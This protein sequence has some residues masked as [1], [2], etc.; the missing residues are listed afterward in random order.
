[1][2]P[3]QRITAFSETQDGG[4]PAGVWIGDALP[5]PIEM[6]KIA[7]EVGYSET[8]FAAKQPDGT[9]KVRYYSPEAEVPFCGH[10]TI[11]LGA[12]LGKDVGDG[13]YQLETA[14]GTVPVSTKTIANGTRAE[15]FSV[16]TNSV[17]APSGLLGKALNTLSW[18]ETVLH[19]SYPPAVAF[20]GAYH[21]ILALKSRE[22]L[23]A[24][25]YEFEELKALMLEHDLTTV[26][27]FWRESAT[28]FHARNLFPVGGIVED[29]ATGAA[30]A[31]LGGYLR[32]H[33]FVDAPGQFTIHQ[34]VD[35]GRPSL[36]QVRVPIAG[37]VSVSGAA[38]RLE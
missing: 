30:A 32:D 29:P 10:A 19:P 15:L 14:I 7:A 28:V 1:M 24:I 34:G 31:A 20:A 18:D 35:M 13:T 5:D 37:G 16:D 38:T 23:S 25:E 3:L 22:Q 27:L 33:S 8:A 2:D 9:Y 17:P 11:A 12:R 36:L 6:L 26:A 21:L 4:N